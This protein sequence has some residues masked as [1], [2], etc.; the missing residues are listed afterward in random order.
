MC[1]YGTLICLGN[2][3]NKQQQQHKL[4][5]Q[6]TCYCCYI[7]HFLP[8]TIERDLLLCYLFVCNIF[9]IYIGSLLFY[10]INMWM[11]WIFFIGVNKHGTKMILALF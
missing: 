4:S 8:S 3:N 9:Y 10:F 2:T 11:D 7:F 6:L 1:V 5:I